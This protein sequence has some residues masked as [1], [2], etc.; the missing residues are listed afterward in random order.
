MGACGNLASIG[1]INGTISAKSIGTI[2]FDRK[3]VEGNTGEFTRT[4]V[5]IQLQRFKGIVVDV[6]GAGTFGE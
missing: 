6:D 4:A 2:P 5:V 1:V 3:T